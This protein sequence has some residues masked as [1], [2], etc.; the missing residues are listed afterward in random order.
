MKQ[1][2]SRN[3]TEEIK[4]NNHVPMHRRPRPP[5]GKYFHP[6]KHRRMGLKSLRKTKKSA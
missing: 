3:E 5:S 4:C 1:K 6:H 2:E